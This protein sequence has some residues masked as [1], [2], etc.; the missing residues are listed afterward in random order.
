MVLTETM[1]VVVF[2]LL[3]FIVLAGLLFYIA[4]V[5]LLPVIKKQLAKYVAYI[6]GLRRSHRALKK[7]AR[8]LKKE[9]ED[10]E[11]Q[12]ERLKERV[13]QWQQ[14]VHEQRNAL[15]RE[16]D[17]RKK[18]LLKQFEEHKEQIALYRTYKQ[19]V[20]EAIEEARQE[21]KKKFTKDAA[22]KSYIKKL[23]LDMRS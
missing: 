20:P 2:K 14:N 22:Q 10:D 16:R 15:I 9:M 5:H 23:M 1:T 6:E 4:Y 21:L 7:D 13:K 18:A 8:L 12:L 17:A 3:N 19:L 11:Q